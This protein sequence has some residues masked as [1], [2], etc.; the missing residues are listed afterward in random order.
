MDW[1]FDA[2]RQLS[3]YPR[4]DVL[5]TAIPEARAINGSLVAV[6]H[7][8]RNAQVLRHF[9][10]PIAPIVTPRTYDFPSPPGLKPYASQMVTTNFLVT[11]PRCFC[12]SD[13]GV[14]KTNAALWAADW[15]M[16][17]HPPGTFRC[18]I[19]APLS[20]LQTV[21]AN[22]I[23]KNFL[24]HRR[25]EILHGDAARRTKALA[26]D[27]DFYIVNPDGVGVGARTGKGITLDGFSKLL[28]ERFDIRLAI[29]DEAS[30]Y[31]DAQTKRHRIARMVFGRKDY[32]WLMTGTPVPNAPTDAY[33]LAKLVNNAWGKSFTTF[34]FETM[35]K[36]TEF[37][38]VP[39]RDG[40]EKARRLL[41]PSIRYDISEVWDAPPTTTQV[42]E[43]QLTPQQTKLLAALKRD[44]QIEIKPGQPIGVINEAGARLKFMQI[45]AGAVYDGAHVAHAVDA[46]PRL[47]E[48]ETVIEETSRKVVIFA[49]LT[50]I[51][52]LLYKRLSKRWP[53]IIINGAISP[54]ER[55]YALGEFGRDG[56]PRIALCDPAA[57]AHGI[58]DLV[59]AD[60]CIFA[61]PLDKTELYLQGIKRLV[62]PG[63]KFPTTIVQIVSTKLEREIFARLERNETLQGLLLQAIERGDF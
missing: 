1:F 10:Y 19:V 34:R 54:K 12:L 49:G 33:G 2:S 6:P 37:K 7:T 53:C 8:L 51:I 60:T 9:Q 22:A 15:L 40:Y 18:L 13:M 44:L 39:Q 16:R 47:S 30:N 25:F 56:G 28:A 62:R 57:T 61:T 38:W 17:Q 46:E 27:A 63:Q 59:S 24:S 21:W 14:G 41:S 48:I 31:K 29:V 52:D 45:A 4:S 26:R 11:H 5:L 23:F 36:L 35:H 55:A 42:R 3:V 32:L 58:N 50:S 20:I 43:V